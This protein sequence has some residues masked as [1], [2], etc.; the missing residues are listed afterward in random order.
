MAELSTG[1]QIAH[2]LTES[3]KSAS[4]MTHLVKSL[5]EGSMQKGLTRIGDYFQDEIAI[6][7]KTYLKKGVI[8]G[9]VGGS[10]GTL[11]I[12]G[13][14]YGAYRLIKKKKNEIAQDAEQLARH[15][16]EGQSII[17][18]MKNNHEI[19][20]STDQG[21]SSE[22]LIDIAPTNQQICHDI[23]SS[24]ENLGEENN[25]Q[26]NFVE[27]DSDVPA[28]ELTADEDN[29]ET[30]LRDD[31]VPDAETNHEGNQPENRA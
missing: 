2:L 21:I 4:D 29:N 14:A 24:D 16:A 28:D 18:A 7:A 9:V 6:T 25:I 19:V 1:M 23:Y 8:K 11:I 27:I 5:G 12:G 10:T 31:I 30:K 22:L 17:N 26:T 13:C 20:D 15:E 3:G